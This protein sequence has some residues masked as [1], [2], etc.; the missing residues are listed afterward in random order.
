MLIRTRLQTL[1][2]ITA[3]L[4]AQP[5]FASPAQEGQETSASRFI[6][7]AAKDKF[8]RS[9]IANSGMSIEAVR[10]DSVWGFAT[11]KMVQ[12]L[13]ASGFIVL[14]D[15]DA[16]VARGGHQYGFDFPAADARYHNYSE[17]TSKLKMLVQSHADIAK[18]S[19]I[20]KT[21]EGRDVWALNINTNPES[22]TSRASSKPGMIYVGNHHAREHLSA[23]VP[24]MFA[25]YLLQNRNQPEIATLLDTRD[26]WI[27]PMLNPDGVEF[28]I[29]TGRYQY[30]RKN[31][32]NNGDGTFGVDLNRNYGFQWGTGGSSTNTSSDVYM[33]TQP[34]SEP[35]TQL[36]KTFV[37]AR[38]NA[39]ILLS[40]HT[41]SE[42]ILYP[43]GHTHD[44]IPKQEDLKVYEKM[45]RTMASWNKYTPQQSSD[46]YIASGDTTDWSYGQLGIFSFTF[47]LSPA[48]SLGA[49]GFY[50]G[51]KM[52]DKAF[53]D[54]LKPMLY[55][56]DLANDPYRALSSAPTGFLKNY[57]QPQAET[58][59]YWSKN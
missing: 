55:L 24:L 10:S 50:P 18:L 36:F 12:E 56:L 52:V 20:G 5:C 53:N 47:E 38:T 4:L 48:N 39:K 40:F 27:V 42:L 31:R 8:E 35:E 15:F 46:L 2:L 30:W 43:W 16:A 13:K 29:A 32:R 34:F 26:I 17:L 1:F 51:P 33:G 3:C 54:N 14:G 37:E 58:S 11:R 44:S 59:K 7:V 23:E 21:I 6:Q 9:K 25:Q 45:A 19:S 57:I 22:L 41:F 49:G 28:D